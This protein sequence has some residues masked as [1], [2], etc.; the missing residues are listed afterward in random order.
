[1]RQPLTQCW[2]QPNIGGLGRDAPFP[3]LWSSVPTF[4]QSFGHGVIKETGPECKAAVCGGGRRRTI[5]VAHEEV[6]GL[7]GEARRVARTFKL[8]VDAT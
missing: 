6:F 5:V 7:R 1:M 3:N 2:S 8:Q 4:T